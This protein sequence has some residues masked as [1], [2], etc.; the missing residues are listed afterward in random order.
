MEDMCPKNTLLQNVFS[1]YRSSTEVSTTPSRGLSRARS[2]ALLLA[3]CFLSLLLSVAW[4]SSAP[5][6]LM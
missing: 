2:L 5:T 6:A 3:R 4:T 1:Y